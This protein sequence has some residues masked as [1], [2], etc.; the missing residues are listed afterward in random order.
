MK[1]VPPGLLKRL[2]KRNKVIEWL[3]GW[4][5]EVK[6]I[7]GKASIVL[8]GS[9]ARGDFNVWSDVDLVLVWEGFSDKRLMERWR[10]VKPLVENTI[11]PLDLI[12]WGPR[13]AKEMLK[14]PSW[15]LAL[16]DC[17]ILIDDYVVFQQLGCRRVSC[18]TV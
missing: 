5:K 8:F 6:G 10:M 11:E 9:Y 3:C 1:S 13:E 14:K 7:L 17:I 18:N 12:L 16:K 4:V 2:A 15:K